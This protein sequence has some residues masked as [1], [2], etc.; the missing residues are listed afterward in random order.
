MRHT[1]NG[2]YHKINPSTTNIKQT[3][4]LKIIHFILYMHGCVHINK[5]IKQYYTKYLITEKL[6]L[7]IQN[8]AFQSCEVNRSKRWTLIQRF[9]LIQASHENR[10]LLN[11]K[12]WCFDLV[13]ISWKERVINPHEC[14]AHRYTAL[15]KNKSQLQR[16]LLRRQKAVNA[17]R[18]SSWGSLNMNA[19][20]LVLAC[21]T[22]MDTDAWGGDSACVCVCLCARERKT[23]VTEADVCTCQGRYPAHVCVYLQMWAVWWDIF[24]QG[25]LSRYGTWV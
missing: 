21:G 10:K 17:S 13:V 3:C 20:I 6:W 11:S 24:K 12:L 14:T 2:H 8:Q 1:R 4:S 18:S 23:E 16:R 22:E 25:C 19:R 9:K 5:E 7:T 15:S